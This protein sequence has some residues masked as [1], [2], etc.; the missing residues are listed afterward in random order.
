MTGFISAVGWTGAILLATCGLPQMYKSVRTRNFQGLSLLFIL[1]WGF[2]EIFTLY[3]VI[4]K[5]FRWPLVFNY[6]I[7][8]TVVF[9]IVLFYMKYGNKKP[10]IRIGNKK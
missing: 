6:G 1:W 7:N 2:G 9:V 10:G 5:A 3:Y 4:E 8:I